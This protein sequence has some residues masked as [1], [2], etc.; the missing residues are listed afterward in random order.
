[1]I[2]GTTQDLR[3]NRIDFDT[4][5]L[6]NAQIDQLP[7]PLS[8]LP[9]AQVGDSVKAFIFTDSQANLVATLEQPRVGIDCCACLK[10]AGVSNAGAFLD[11]GIAKQ[12]L[13]P[14]AE[15]RR[16][17]EV[18]Q[19]ECVLVYLDNSGRLAATSRLD[20]HLP[21]NW[22]GL[23][24]WEPVQL[25]IYQRT[26]LGF[27]AVIND[28]AIGLIYKDEVFQPLKVGQTVQGFVKQHRADGRIDLALQSRPSEVRDELCDAVMAYLDSNNGV[29]Q[30]TDK[31]DPQEI[32]ATFKVSKKNFKRA[33][34][35]L[36]KQRLIA[37]EADR[38]VLV[39]KDT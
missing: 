14:F 27:K 33:L 34:A 26:D 19:Y 2:I 30:L 13:L 23:K 20:H 16:P 25:L 38:V 9:D 22:P 12:L 6:E 28:Q 15:Q 7:M 37:I 3:I 11:W 32:Y 5:W 29:S 4:I 21:D 10:V 36:Y 35:T 8:E 39:K 31:S 17:L 24:T 1:M 18:G